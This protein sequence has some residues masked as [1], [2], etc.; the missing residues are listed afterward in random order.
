MK[1][2]I[3]ECTKRRIKRKLNL[4][5]HFPNTHLALRTQLKKNL[6]RHMVINYSIKLNC[7]KSW[8]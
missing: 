8:V 1:S 2:S 3:I 4:M 5:I 6:W 7:K